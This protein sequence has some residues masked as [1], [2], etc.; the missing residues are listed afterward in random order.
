MTPGMAS[1]TLLTLSDYETLAADGERHELDRGELR[2]MTFPRWPHTL[3]QH[4][5]YES[6]LLYLQERPIGRVFMDAGFLLEQ[7]PPTLRG[8]DVAFLTRDRLRKIQGD[9]WATGAPDLAVEV[10]SPSETAADLRAKVKQYLA[11]GAACVWVVYP[12]TRELH[13][14]PAGGPPAVLDAEAHIEEPSLLPGYSHLVGGLFED[15]DQN[16]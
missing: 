2:T 1:R 11:S 5:I 15:L 14:Y 9:V 7:D 13:R 10:V 3:V 4:R 16:P 12:N 8:P 6:I